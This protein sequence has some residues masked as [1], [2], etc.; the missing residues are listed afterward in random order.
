MASLLHTNRQNIK[1]VIY[2]A[3]TQI[4]TIKKKN[5]ENDNIESYIPIKKDKI[6]EKKHQYSYQPININFKKLAKKLPIE[7]TKEAKKKRYELFNLFDPNANGY[8]S[9]AE[10][11]KGFR[12]I[13][14]L[15]ELQRWCAP[16]FLRAYYAAKNIDNQSKHKKAN[17][18]IER[19]EFRMLLIYLR[20]YFEYYSVYSQGDLNRDK[21]LDFNEFNNLIPLLKSYGLHIRDAYTTFH[22][23]DINNGGMILFDE[24]CDWAFQQRLDV[25]KNNDELDVFKY[26]N[27]NKPDKDIEESIYDQVSSIQAI[28]SEVEEGLTNININ[29]PITSYINI[30]FNE[31]AKKLPIENTKEAK[32][33]RYELFNLFDPNANGYLSLAEIEK[34]FR[35]ILNLSELQRWCKPVFLRAYY[36]AKNINNQSKSK[37]ANDYIERSEFRI[38]LMYLRQYFEYYY[39][40]TS[41]DKNY[42]H[43]IDFNEFK[44]YCIPILNMINFHN[45]DDKN[46]RELF[47]EI[48]VNHGNIILFDEFCH[49]AITKQLDYIKTQEEENDEEENNILLLH[50]LLHINTISSKNLLGDIIV[51]LNQ[52]HSLS[53]DYQQFNELLPTSNSLA[54]IKRCDKLFKLFDINTNGYLSLAEIEKGFRDILHYS[55]LIK[56]AAPVFLRAY[57]IAKNYNQKKKKKKKFSS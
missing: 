3:D 8:L 21:R 10:I 46:A 17:D 50:S 57:Y 35:D 16:V 1:E 7:N 6:K 20:Q 33:E 18:Y 55:D 13:L 5:Q 9:L 29:T 32:K 28:E 34:G 22:E 37:Q 40:Y 45:I 42:D 49:W 11:E 27:K 48:D 36:A 14:N 30:D 26:Y 38:L 19:S 41:I 4:K 47:N 25:I 43:R 39:L 24:F 2:S 54:D 23:I 56:I 53:L 51:N 52:L 44:T 12:D 31:L 15:P